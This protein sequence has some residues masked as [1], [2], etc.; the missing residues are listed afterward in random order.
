MK[1]NTTSG[2]STAGAPGATG[3]T[4]GELYVTALA[5]SLRGQIEHAAQHAAR[6]AAKQPESL[7]SP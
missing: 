2:P 6:H 5:L 7:I 1:A 4:S 3:E